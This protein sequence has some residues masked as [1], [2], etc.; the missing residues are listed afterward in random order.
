MCFFVLKQLFPS[1]FVLLI[2][3]CPKHVLFKYT[4]QP[5]IMLCVVQHS[6]LNLLLLV[7]VI[8]NLVRLNGN[9]IGWNFVAVGFT[10]NVM[11]WLGCLCESGGSSAIILT[12]T[13][14]N[15]CL[16]FSV[17]KPILMLLVLF[18]NLEWYQEEAVLTA[19]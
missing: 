4:W 14:T 19:V 12:L 15:W 6:I 16:L 11:I 9:M 3:G 5:C 2:Y 18:L 13:F 17:A 7:L 1:L 10:I 8:W